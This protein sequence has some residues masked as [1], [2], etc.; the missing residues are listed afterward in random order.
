MPLAIAVGDIDTATTTKGEIALGL[1]GTK[2]VSL[3]NLACDDSGTANCSAPVLST[4]R[5]PRGPT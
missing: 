2:K 4:C 5:R 1:V 3:L